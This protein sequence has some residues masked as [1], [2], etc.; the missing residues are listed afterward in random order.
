MR[1]LR[2]LDRQLNLPG[3]A[4]EFL[5]Q[6]QRRGV[7]QVRAADLDDL[8]PLAAAFSASTSCELLQRGNQLV[9]ESPCATAT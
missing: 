2:P 7:G 4:A 1:R 8:V 6:P 3:E 9:L 5:A